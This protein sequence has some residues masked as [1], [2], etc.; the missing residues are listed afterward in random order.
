MAFWSKK[1]T[2]PSWTAAAATGGQKQGISARKRYS[3]RCVTTGVP[4][5]V[6]VNLK[7]EARTLADTLDQTICGIG[8]EWGAALSL[9]HVATAGLAL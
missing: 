1:T 8:G 9:E 2:G 6:H 7:R 3:C 5:H 4:Q